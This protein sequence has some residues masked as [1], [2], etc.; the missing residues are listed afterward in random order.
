MFVL[1][2][3]RC[4]VGCVRDGGTSMVAVPPW[5]EYFVDL[6]RFSRLCIGLTVVLC[7]QC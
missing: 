1:R 6:Q 7:V 5:F 4:A 3:D 2:V